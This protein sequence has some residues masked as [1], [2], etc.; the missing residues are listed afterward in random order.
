MW[1][2]NRRIGCQAP[3]RVT[4]LEGFALVLGGVALFIAIL[5]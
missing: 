1:R 3:F 4:I 5:T 2:I